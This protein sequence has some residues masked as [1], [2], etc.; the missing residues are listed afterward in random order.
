MKWTVPQTGQRRVIKKFAWY[1]V[2]LSG[3]NTKIWW[4]PY[5]ACQE[6]DYMLGI[7]RWVT[8]RVTQDINYVE[9][10]KKY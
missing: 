2:K 6:Y 7:K 3:I 1:P 10:W 4:E 5:F 9:E 8:G